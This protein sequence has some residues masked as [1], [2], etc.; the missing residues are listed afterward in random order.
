[1]FIF[2]C[3]GQ[4]KKASTKKS[5][6]SASDQDGLKRGASAFQLN[7]FTISAVR[8]NPLNP[9]DGTIY[10]KL[11]ADGNGIIT[12]EEISRALSR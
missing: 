10:T 4:P 3:A 2:M 6:R 8:M 9:N 1:M 5:G 7:A 12:E 11:D